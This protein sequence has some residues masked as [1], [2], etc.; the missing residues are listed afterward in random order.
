[1]RDEREAAPNGGGARHTRGDARVF[2]LGRSLSFWV[3]LCRSSLPRNT[4]AKDSRP[5]SKTLADT[6]VSTT[7]AVSKTLTDTG[8]S[9]TP[10]LV[11]RTPI[12]VR[13]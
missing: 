4:P 13:R 2:V 8:V 3:V 10:T 1:M 9:K 7:L 11:V 5:V 6:D 12:L